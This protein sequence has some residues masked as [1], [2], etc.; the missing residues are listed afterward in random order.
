MRIRKG[1]PITTR[2]SNRPSARYLIVGVGN[3]TLSDDGIGLC[4]LQEAQRRLASVYPCLD[5]AESHA[6]G[7]EFIDLLPGHRGVVIVDS[8]VTGTLSPGEFRVFDLEELKA[9]GRSGVFSSHGLQLP[10]LVEMGNVCGLDMPESIYAV[11]IEA[12]DV[13]TFSETPTE[14]LKRSVNPVVNELERLLR[15]WMDSAGP[16]PHPEKRS[17]LCK[18]KR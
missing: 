4:V 5:F 16:S 3:A 17:A 1:T 13:V 8:M 9:F 10:A 2:P 6:G 18:E 7:F 14:E 15:E 12:R 11:G